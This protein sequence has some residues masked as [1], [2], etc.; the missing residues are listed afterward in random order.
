MGAL[1]N[2]GDHD[3]LIT[4]DQFAW[5]LGISVKALYRRRERGELPPAAV[6]GG[7]LRWRMSTIEA[8]FDANEAE[9]AR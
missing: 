1:F 3:H 2:F 7:R 8:W 5:L 9:D 6:R 4:S